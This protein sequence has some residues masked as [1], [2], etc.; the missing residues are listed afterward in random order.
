MKNSH[1]TLEIL[2]ICKTYGENVRKVA[3]KVMAHFDG[4]NFEDLSEEDLKVVFDTNRFEVS[5]CRHL[6]YPGVVSVLLTIRHAHS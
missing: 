4:F 2:K 6:T 5:F 1:V 3:I